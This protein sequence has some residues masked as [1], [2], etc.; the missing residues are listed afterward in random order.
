MTALDCPLR[1]CQFSL[2]LH[3]RVWVRLAG[4]CASSAL[5]RSAGILVTAARSPKQ[6]QCP[7]GTAHHP[8]ATSDPRSESRNV[9]ETMCRLATSCAQPAAATT[10]RSTTC[11]R[12][13][14]SPPTRYA[15][16]PKPGTRNAGL[17]CVVWGVGSPDGVRVDPTSNDLRICGAPIW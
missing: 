13:T 15:Q 7:H 10:S 8:R 11:S 4:D 3:L 5:R 2:A 9:N 14:T 12:D 17:G 16:T 6:V 1:V